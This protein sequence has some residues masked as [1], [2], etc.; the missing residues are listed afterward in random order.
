M[1]P[2][3][4]YV[5]KQLL[6]N[7]DQAP[8]LVD[9]LNAALAFSGG[10]RVSGV[11][12]LLMAESDEPPAGWECLATMNDDK[13]RH[14]QLK[15]DIKK[16]GNRARRQQLKR[17]LA[18]NPEEAHLAEPDFGGN[19]SEPLNGADC[20]ATRRRSEEEED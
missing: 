6:G 10:W 15:R 11:D 1:D 16:A 19:S 9:L 4:D 5:F 20:D 3:T 8:L 7:E 13:R 2:K 17:T 14:R 18:D 12:I